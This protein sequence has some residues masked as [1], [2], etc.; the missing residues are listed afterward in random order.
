MD[1]EPLDYNRMRRPALIQEV[2]KERRRTLNLTRR[3]DDLKKELLQANKLLRDKKRDLG[4][5]L[6]KI[7]A[8]NRKLTTERDSL[9]QKLQQEVA[10]GEALREQMQELDQTH[11]DITVSIIRQNA[12]EYQELMKRLDQVK[13]QSTCSICLSQWEANGVHRVVSLRCGHLFGDD[14][15][16][17]NLTIY[18]ECPLCKQAAQIHDLRYIYGYGAL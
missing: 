11:M 17:Q 14:C 1:N 2:L 12:I 18:A 8:A 9:K 4:G 7:K 6:K 13:E 15:I 5:Q 10:N 16:R 3:K